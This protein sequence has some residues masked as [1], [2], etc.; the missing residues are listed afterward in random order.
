MRAVIVHTHS[1]PGATYHRVMRVFAL[2]LKEPA[3]SSTNF[4][5][6]RMVDFAHIDSR[7]EDTPREQ[8]RRSSGAWFGPLVRPATGPICLP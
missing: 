7:Q 4:V 6:E 5:G 3:C 1:R 2:P 8:C